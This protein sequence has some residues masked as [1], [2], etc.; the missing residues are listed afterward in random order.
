M[1]G[2]TPHGLR[3]YQIGLALLGLATIAL[4][5]VVLVQASATK[6]DTKTYEAAQKAATALENYTGSKQTVPDSLA[7]AGVKDVP[8]TIKYTKLSESSYKFCATYR[9]SSTANFSASDIATN[10]LLSQYGGSGASSASGENSDGSAFLIVSS[11]HKKGENCQTIKPTF[12]GGYNYDST[13]SG[14]TTTNPCEKQYQK[15]YNETNYEKCISTPGTSAAPAPSSSGSSSSNNQ[16]A[17]EKAYAA[18]DAQ[19]LGSSQNEQYLACLNAA[20]AANKSTS[21]SSRLHPRLN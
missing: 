14:S 9:A 3:K 10:V 12:Y 18:C 17:L 20:N 13:S 2:N 15:D 1:L 6:S 16:S 7:A 21:T 5:V 4:T 11:S 19:Y 8:D